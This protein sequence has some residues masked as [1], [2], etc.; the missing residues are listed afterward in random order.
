MVHTI[1]SRSLQ[2]YTAIQPDT[3]QIMMG[4][5]MGMG[6]VTVLEMDKVMVMGMVT[7]LEMDKVMVMVMVMV[8]VLVTVTEMDRW[9]G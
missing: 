3:T 2:T 4:M 9:I 6:M 7:V 1:Y 8:M 5:V